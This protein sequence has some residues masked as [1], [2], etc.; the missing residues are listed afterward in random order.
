MINYKKIINNLTNLFQLGLLTTKDI[1]Q[2]IR[3]LIQFKKEKTMN[4]LNNSHS[5]DL[6]ELKN[7][8]N[9]LKLEIQK[10]KKLVGKR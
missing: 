4:E 2:E 5:R 7:K 1:K 8:I 10:L 6:E 9:S 3:N